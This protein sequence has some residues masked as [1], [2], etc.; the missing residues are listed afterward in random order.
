M[1]AK[2]DDFIEQMF[3]A[4]THDNILCFS[5]RG[6][7]YWLKVYE[8]PQGSRISK[9]KPIVNLFPINARRKNKCYFSCKRF[10]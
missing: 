2:D 6:Q 8:V 9:G 3:V 7:V 1:T 5:S 4:N 10:C